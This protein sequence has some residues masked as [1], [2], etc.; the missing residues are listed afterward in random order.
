MEQVQK[1]NLPK[2]T[3]L[4]CDFE[5]GFETSF[6]IQSLKYAVAQAGRVYTNHIKIF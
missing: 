5:P 1:N 3:Q 6:K 2:A 4:L